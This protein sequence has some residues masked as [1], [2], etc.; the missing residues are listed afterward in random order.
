MRKAVNPRNLKVDG[1][2]QLPDGLNT[3]VI[4]GG[5]GLPSSVIQRLILARCIAEKPRLIVL[6]DFFFGLRRADKQK[7]IQM[8][9]HKENPWT[10]LSVSNDPLIME[11]CDRVVVLD[12]GKVRASGS[13]RELLDKQL[14]NDCLE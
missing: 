12:H 9:V 13:F 2:N 14:L 8:L 1:L 5:K 11:A 4:S 7:L 3:H 10:L 6:Q